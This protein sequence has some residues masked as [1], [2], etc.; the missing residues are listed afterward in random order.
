MGFTAV[1]LLVA[2]P[3]VMPERGVINATYLD[4]VAKMV[5]MLAEAGI[6]TI[7]DAHQDVY[8]PRFCGNGFPDW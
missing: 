2:V 1:R 7:L 6:Y 4:E 8:S 3:G 5:E